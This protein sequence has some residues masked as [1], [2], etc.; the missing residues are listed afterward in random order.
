MTQKL[1]DA[2]IVCLLERSIH[3]SCRQYYLLC[4]P[5][6]SKHCTLVTFNHAIEIVS[7]HYDHVRKEEVETNRM[8]QS[9]YR[10]SDFKMKFFLLNFFFLKKSIF[11]SFKNRFS[12]PFC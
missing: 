8:V 11:E 1:L 9:N 4:G 2:L 10:N 3:S 6:R 7:L 12:R 5:W